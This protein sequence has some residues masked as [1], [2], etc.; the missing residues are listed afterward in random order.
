MCLAIYFLF[1]LWILE[2]WA[3]SKII[4]TEGYSLSLGFKNKTHNSFSETSALFFRCC[5]ISELDNCA[6]FLFFKG[7]KIDA[8]EVF[9][10]F[11]YSNSLCII[12]SDQSN[13]II[14]IHNFPL[15]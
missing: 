7:I 15:Q 8:P 5:G 4:N 14:I 1:S 13:I 9:S 2:E 6:D 11:V 3:A 10:P 12:P